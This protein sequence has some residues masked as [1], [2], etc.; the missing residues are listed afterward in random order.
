[1]NKLLFFS[2]TSGVIYELLESYTKKLDV[3][4][5][6]L[7]S[8]PKESCRKCFGRFYTGYNTSQK[9]FKVCEKCIIK[10]ADHKKIQNYINIETPI[11]TSDTCSVDYKK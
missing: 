7:T 11:E 5:I 9:V 3:Y 4:Q 2:L 8:K 1:M 6:P 10:H